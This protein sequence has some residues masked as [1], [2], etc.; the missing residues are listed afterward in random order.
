M[1][2]TY[3]VE[4]IAG[5]CGYA[6][7]FYDYAGGRD[8]LDQW[9]VRENEATMAAYRGQRDGRSIDGLPTLSMAASDRQAAR[10]EG[11][12]ELMSECSRNAP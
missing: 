3:Q 12:F 9:A 5:S 8:L 7:P 4:R 11:G 6:V 1:G 10:A 2:K